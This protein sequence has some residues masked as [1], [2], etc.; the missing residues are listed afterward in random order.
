MF[1]ACVFTRVQ[2]AYYEQ[3]AVL[4]LTPVFSKR[5]CFFHIFKGFSIRRFFVQ[6]GLPGAFFAFREIDQLM[7]ELLF[8]ECFGNVPGTTGPSC[9]SNSLMAASH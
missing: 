4:G 7:R 3:K 1:W 9:A 6:P 8:F 5:F 2:E